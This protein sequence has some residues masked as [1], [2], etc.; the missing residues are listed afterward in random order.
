VRRRDEGLG[1]ILDPLDGNPQPLGDR[2]CNVFF[3]V[4]VDLGPEPAADFGSDRADL[5]LAHPH[6]RRDHRPQDVRVLG[7]RPD[8][9]R[10]F[11][12][13]EVGDHPSRLHGVWHEPLVDHALLDDHLGLCEGAI[14]GGVVDALEVET[15]A[16]TTRHE[17]HGQVVGKARVNDNGLAG[18]CQFGVDDCRKGIVGDDDRVRRIARDVAVGSHDYGDRL[19][20]EADDIGSDG[21]MFG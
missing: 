7:R 12:R 21:P 16:G 15:H 8:G 10:S 18:H 4:D 14:N 19:A 20:C 13:L 17:G 9:H 5:I 3:G 6:H 2:G 1:T 11:A